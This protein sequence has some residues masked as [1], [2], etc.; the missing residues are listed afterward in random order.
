M[1]IK[2]IEET[3]K[4]K[5]LKKLLKTRTRRNLKRR[6]IRLEKVVKTRLERRRK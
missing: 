2:P 1:I 4:N 5:K 6:H 3:M